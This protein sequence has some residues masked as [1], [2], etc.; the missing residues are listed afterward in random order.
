MASDSGAEEEGQ[1]GQHIPGFLE[2]TGPATSHL[3]SLEW[4]T[5]AFRDRR[6]KQADSLREVPFL[7]EH[8]E[9]EFSLLVGFIGGGH[10]D[11]L[12]GR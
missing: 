2:V 12:A 11:I 10:D 7:R 9:D 8:P 3:Q 4:A 6:G 5:W 1:P